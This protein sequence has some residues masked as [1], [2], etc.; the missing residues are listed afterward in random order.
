MT[1]QIIHHT[2]TGDDLVAT[3][4]Y[5]NDGTVMLVWETIAALQAW[6]VEQL[7]K[8]HAINPAQDAARLL[9]DTY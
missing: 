5:Q 2:A 1:D 9:W 3:Y 8:Y 6:Q 4:Y 7:A